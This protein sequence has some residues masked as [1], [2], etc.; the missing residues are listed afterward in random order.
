MPKNQART[1][2]AATIRAH[3]RTITTS[4]QNT[5]VTNDVSACT[6][7]ATAAECHR[8]TTRPTCAGESKSLSPPHTHRNCQHAPGSASC[9]QLRQQACDE[10]LF[11]QRH[12]ELPRRASKE[13][14]YAAVQLH[15][16]QPPE[17]FRPATDRKRTP[18][19]RCSCPF[20][21]PVV[22][23]ENSGSSA[24]ASRLPMT[25]PWP[26]TS[27]PRILA[28]RYVKC[29]TRPATNCCSPAC[30]SFRALESS[31]NGGMITSSTQLDHPIVHV[32]PAF[33]R[34]TGY[35][36]EE[37]IGQKAALAR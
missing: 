6:C 18:S 5:V 24:P 28:K 17:T 30:A 27:S 32:N 4:F 11:L 29:V 31:H 3:R 21:P 2:K 23:W 14:A 16:T 10:K 26:S 13:F 20:L 12:C 33:E 9:S 36:P 35:R 22:T 15:N 37:V 19:L 1:G 34:I 25:K 8:K 7:A